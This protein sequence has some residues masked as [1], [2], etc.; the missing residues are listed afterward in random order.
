MVSISGYEIPVISCGTAVVGSGA[1]GLNAADR[2]FHYGCKD[3]VL[4]TEGMKSGTS[5]N[6]GSDKQTYYKLSMAGSDPDSVRRMAEVL[7][8]GGCVDG[9]TALCE[10]ALSASCFLR[11]AELGVP[12][13]QNRYGEYIGYKTDHDPARRASSA[14]PYTSKL[15]TECLE[16][17]VLKNG[18]EI[19]D[20][21]QAVRILKADGKIAGLLCLNVKEKRKV[22]YL[23]INCRSIILA[24]GGPAGLYADRVYPDSQYGATGLAFEAG[25]AGRNLTEWQY[26]LAS[27]S[28]RWNVSGTYMQALPVF[29]SAEPDGSGEREFLNDGYEDLSELCGNVFL[30]GYQWPFDV[31]KREGSSRIDLLVYQ[32]TKIRGRRVFLDYRRN[33]G[34]KI[35]YDTLPEEAKRYLEQADACFGTPAERLIHMNRPAYEFFLDHGVDLKRQRI[36]IALC[37][38]HNNGGLA[39]DCWWQTNV[40]GLFGA[41][42]VCGTH[43]VYRPGGTA[44]N[45][46]QV[47][48]VRAAQYICA[49]RNG[50]VSRE[51]EF[52]EAVREQVRERITMADRAFA[53][54][55]KERAASGNG[56]VFEGTVSQIR[57]ASDIFMEAEERMSRAGAAVRDTEGIREALFETEEQLR[58]FDRIAAEKSEAGLLFRTWEMLLCQKI[59]LEAMLDYR[60]QGGVSRGS[61]W[62]PQDGEDSAA[63]DGTEGRIQEVVLNGTDT[64]FSWRKPREIPDGD[65]FFENVWREYRKDKNIR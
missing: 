55:E 3:I 12:F 57:T 15:M 34:G 29:V 19:L 63:C 58:N 39:V 50:A 61:A 9:D 23:L 64:V 26:G 44:L 38:Q 48:S 14:G 54:K 1:A 8:G 53:A 31:R 4:V 41:G 42:E 35:P 49:H 13:P 62:Y 5:R 28:P 32:E 43:G 22:S 60:K 17:Q 18:T 59:Y 6:T 20:G 36:E 40:E 52:A 47:G 11:L 7:Y 46:G 27:L 45:S 16:A 51:E 2:L 10:A 25:A 30:K 24:T 65:D 56:A 33:P 37:A 21:Y